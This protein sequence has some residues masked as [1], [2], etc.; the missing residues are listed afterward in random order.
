MKT[1]GKQETFF[2]EN[3]PETA[4]GRGAAAAIAIAGGLALTLGVGLLDYLTGFEVSFSVFYLLPTAFLAWRGGRNMGLLG[5]AMASTVWLVVD[6]IS[7]YPHS[8]PWIMY[9][10]AAVRLVFFVITAQLISRQKLVHTLEQQLSRTD[11]LTGLM[12]VRSFFE[13]GERVLALGARHARPLTMVFIDLDNFKQVNDRRG[14]QEGDRLIKLV[15][16]GLLRSVRTSD[17]AARLGGDEFGLLLPETG[18]EE[19]ALLIGRLRQ[20]LDAEVDRAYWSISYSVGAVTFT[21]PPVNLKTAT[22]MA[23]QLMYEAK[24]GGKNLWLH[25][26]ADSATDPEACAPA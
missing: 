2:P 9:W 24:N 14:H 15:G 23:D 5:A 16:R 4:E 26:S 19:A 12:N 3:N 21:T 20:R 11:S 25:R 17:L 18:F 10:N 13:D 22:A 7:G 8:Q 1:P 6:Y